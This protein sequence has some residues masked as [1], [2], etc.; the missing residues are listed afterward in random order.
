MNK[1]LSVLCLLLLG[2]L[3]IS[4]ARAAI[5]FAVYTTTN[6][7]TTQAGV[8]GGTYSANTNVPEGSYMNSSTAIKISLTNSAGDAIPFVRL[9]NLLLSVSTNWAGGGSGNFDAAGAGFKFGPED[10]INKPVARIYD[11]NDVDV[12]ENAPSL[13]GYNVINTNLDGL[14]A[15][16]I[17]ITAVNI[18]ELFGNN[19]NLNPSQVG[20]T[21]TFT[22]SGTA[23]TNQGN[24]NGSGQGNIAIT[25]VP[26]PGSSGL[27]G[28]AV[29]GMMRHRRRNKLA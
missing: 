18:P 5:T 20:D 23:E 21:V 27:L 4:S 25:S 11:E 29:L 16:S 8:M 6:Q 2:V 15:Y 7:T 13:I 3:G 9:S 12:T 19:P 17:V 24:M 28:L 10:G 26:E 1:N 22:V 14:G